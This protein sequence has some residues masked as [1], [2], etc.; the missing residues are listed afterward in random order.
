MSGHVIKFYPRFLCITKTSLLREE[1]EWYFMP[2][3]YNSPGKIHTQVQLLREETPCVLLPD[4][5]LKHYCVLL[6]LH[7]WNKFIIEEKLILADKKFTYKRGWVSWCARY[8]LWPAEK[9]FEG[10]CNQYKRRFE[11]NSGM[12]KFSYSKPFEAQQ[13]L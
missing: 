8:L 13:K 12:I 5:T 2:C 9:T 3:Q 11:D 10:F 1:S 6:Q 7:Q 4:I